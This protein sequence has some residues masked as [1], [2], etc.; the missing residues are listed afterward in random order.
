MS[1][2]IKTIP[3]EPTE[4]ERRCAD[5]AHREEQRRRI[6]SLLEGNKGAAVIEIYQ[7]GGGTY[8]KVHFGADVDRRIVERLSRRS[9]VSKPTPQT[10]RAT[11][12][13]IAG[14]LA[15]RR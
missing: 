14:I 2:E 8:C 11:P 10:L 1:I 6:R 9:G 3:V 13:E 5:K 7:L 4:L 12:S 15:A